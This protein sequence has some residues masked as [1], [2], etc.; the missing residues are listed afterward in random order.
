MP[1]IVGYAYLQVSKIIVLLYSYYLKLIGTELK[2]ITY[3]SFI[4]ICTRLT[5][6]VHACTSFDATNKVR[7]RYKILMV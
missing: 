6:S 5:L 4:L 7:H 2:L 3:Q 1:W